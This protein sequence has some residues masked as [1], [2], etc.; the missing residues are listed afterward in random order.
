M[1][2][3]TVMLLSFQVRRRTVGTEYQQESLMEALLH[4]SV[5]R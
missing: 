1:E 3:K 4:H 5:N 2:Q